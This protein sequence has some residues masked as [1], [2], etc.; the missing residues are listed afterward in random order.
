VVVTVLDGNGKPVF[1]LNGRPGAKVFHMGDATFVDGGPQC[2][3]FPK[4][5][6]SHPASSKGWLKS[7]RVWI[8]SICTLVECKVSS[9]PKMPLPVVAGTCSTMS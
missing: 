5:I 4:I 6:W 8:Y 1:N 2:L 7:G 9:A 3:I